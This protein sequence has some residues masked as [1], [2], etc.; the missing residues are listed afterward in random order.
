MDT[1]YTALQP[2]LTYKLPGGKSTVTF[3]TDQAEVTASPTDNKGVGTVAKPVTPS[4]TDQAWIKFCKT[5]GAGMG[6]GLS[7]S[8]RPL[9]AK[10][11][12]ETL[13]KGGIPPRLA[14]A[15]GLM[16]SELVINPVVIGC[17]TTTA[18][19]ISSRIQRMVTG[20]NVVGDPKKSPDY[21]RDL[22]DAIGVGFTTMAFALA[23]ENAGKPPAET[24]WDVYAPAL[25]A[26]SLTGALAALTAMMG[27]EIR[28][29]DALMQEKELTPNHDL[30]METPPELAFE[31][32]KESKYNKD[33]L[34]S[35]H[36]ADDSQ[37]QRASCGK[38]LCTRLKLSSKDLAALDV[39]IK[40]RMKAAFEMN[41][42]MVLDFVPVIH[43]Q[44]LLA[45]VLPMINP[46]KENI[47]GLHDTE[48]MTKE[49]QYK[50]ITALATALVHNKRV[51]GWTN[52]L[53]GTPTPKKDLNHTD[54][55]KLFTGQFGKLAKQLVPALVNGAVTLV[56]SYISAVALPNR[57][58]SDAVD[59]QFAGWS[60]LDKGTPQQVLQLAGGM[61]G[62][63]LLL[64]LAAGS[65][66]G[67]RMREV[68][69][70]I[71]SGG[72]AGAS[73][74]VP[75]QLG[76]V[77]GSASHALV[78]PTHDNLVLPK[79]KEE[80]L[81]NDSTAGDKEYAKAYAQGFTNDGALGYAKQIITKPLKSMA[82]G[83]YHAITQARSLVPAALGGTAGGA[84]GG[85]LIAA[86]LTA[87]GIVS[88]PGVP[89]AFAVGAGASLVGT[90]L[91]LLTTYCRNAKTTSSVTPDNKEGSSGQ[92]VEVEM[93]TTD[94]QALP[95][96]D[97]TGEK[98]TLMD[99]K[100]LSIP[101][102]PEKPIS[103]IPDQAS[104]GPDTFTS[105]RKAGATHKSDSDENLEHTTHLHPSP[106][107]TP[108]T[109]PTTGS[110][111]SNSST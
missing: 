24:S 95:S 33:D 108:P 47:L 102:T 38:R 3:G 57:K 42:E 103:D 65:G 76:A 34:E 32:P 63:M 51:E 64:R 68:V 79:A 105:P 92:K 36:G 43:A 67:V 50:L 8:F 93:Q 44:I 2:G 78:H 56:A 52:Y 73:G 69:T 18:E 19:L 1:K 53:T 86:G 54:F 100:N 29:L 23:Y 74:S 72:F 41:R 20:G 88:M 39:F 11:S 61:L 110:D 58:F 77:I 21:L 22:G 26:G 81:S 107:T 91:G 13:L 55:N 71:V 89:V 25:L 7:W 6:T 62:G 12:E 48:H 82:K 75:A 15:I 85:G 66:E 101:V 87:G 5:L 17:G 49:T 28:Q 9:M 37:A 70:S 104:L 35:G 90:G 16:L 96:G 84:L 111:V 14:T 30:V 109:K 83:G 99:H 27:K 60:D 40:D 31:G 4:K 10:I 45:Y 97:G 106:N 98:S 94:T 59:Q 46:G 80:V